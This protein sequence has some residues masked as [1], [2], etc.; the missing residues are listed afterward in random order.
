[1]PIC[2]VPNVMECWDLFLG[3]WLQLAQKY[4][5]LRERMSRARDGICYT[6]MD[7]IATKGM[8]WMDFFLCTGGAKLSSWKAAESSIWLL[9]QYWPMPKDPIDANYQV[10]EVSFDQNVLWHNIE[11]ASS[12]HAGKGEYLVWQGRSYQNCNNANPPNWTSLCSPDSPF[13]Y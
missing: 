13:L 1:M 9:R 5:V 10:V 8:V 4:W 7:D 12:N 2:K 6:T 3:K 11:K